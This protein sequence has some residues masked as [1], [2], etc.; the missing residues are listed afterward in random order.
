MDKR[1]YCC[2]IYFIVTFNFVLLNI[3]S[4]PTHKTLFIA[5]LSEEHITIFTLNETHLT[6]KL[7]CKIVGYTLSSFDNKLPVLRANGGSA[8]GFSPDI[9]LRQYAPQFQNLPE[10]LLITLHYKQK[11]IT[12]TTIYRRPGQ[13]IPLDFFTYISNNF[14]FYIIMADIKNTVDELEQKMTFRT[15]SLSRL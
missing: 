12:I 10:H 2:N 5:P 14:R 6:P 9:A 8:I 3:R 7:Q 13:P 1:Q 15:S 4:L 11:Y